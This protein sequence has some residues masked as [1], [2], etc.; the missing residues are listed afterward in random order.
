MAGPGMI[1][2]VA[3]LVLL[4]AI[5]SSAF[6][7]IKVAVGTIPPLSVAAARIVIAAVFLYLYARIIKES[8]P[9]FGKTWVMFFLI[10]LFGNGLPFTLIS[11]GELRVD[12]GLAAIL[13]SIMP[14]VTLLLVHLFTEDERITPGKVVGVFLGLGGVVVLVG[15]QALLN[16]GGD[17]VY[18]LA[19]T[20]GAVCYAIASVI[21]RRLPPS[22]PVGRSAAV[23][24]CASLQMIPLS[25]YLDRPW[26]LSPTPEA[27]G[28]VAFL[29]LIATAIAT[30]IYFIVVSAKGA[31]FL[32]FINYMIPL[33]GVF[34][35]ATL[36]G[37][38]VEPK[39]L[40]ALALILAGLAIANYKSK[41]PSGEKTRISKGP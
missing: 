29:G 15:P 36:L 33:M 23:M 2:Y 18:Q 35:G 7:F 27:L 30:V 9:P 13:M 22:P 24:I 17:A 20:G 32:S 34:W 4:A 1:R 16:L 21:A 39:A 5:W 37:E 14:L 3:L 19:V 31:T 25:L 6:V 38:Q 26:T 10:G 28:S 8:L 12:S 40:A 41:A 11:W